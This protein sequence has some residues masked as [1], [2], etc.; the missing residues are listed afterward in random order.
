MKEDPDWISGRFIGRMPELLRS[1]KALDV[2]QQVRKAAQANLRTTLGSQ[3]TEKEGERIM[4]FAFDPK[5]T[6]EQNIKMLEMD[7]AN[8]KARKARLDEQNQ[9]FLNNKRSM[10]GW[11]APQ[12]N[13]YNP[14][15]NLKEDANK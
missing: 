2:M 8:L 4:G 1:K 6:P 5:L 7:I 3:F 13:T 11:T 12:L 15:V 14:F 10:R 9:H